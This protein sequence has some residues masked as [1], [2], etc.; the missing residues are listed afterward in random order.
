MAQALLTPEM[1]LC[2]LLRETAEIVIQAEREVAAHF[3][4]I[5]LQQKKDC[6]LNQRSGNVIENKGRPF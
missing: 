6:F 5:Y 3:H 2:P 4:E 1:A